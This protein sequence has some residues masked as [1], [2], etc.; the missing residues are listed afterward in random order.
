MESYLRIYKANV[1]QALISAIPLAFLDSMICWWI[2]RSLLETVRVLKLRRNI[3][4]LMLY[5]DFSITLLF[6]VIGSVIFML[7]S[8]R[9]HK[10]VSCVTVSLFAKI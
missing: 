3:V 2:F 5:R 6:A 10:L 1:D 7:Y 8:I 4:K 9:E